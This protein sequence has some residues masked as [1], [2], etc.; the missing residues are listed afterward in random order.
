MSPDQRRTTLWLLRGGMVLIVTAWISAY[1]ALP[2]FLSPVEFDWPCSVYA[3]ANSRATARHTFEDERNYLLRFLNSLH[4]GGATFTADPVE[5]TEFSERLIRS[6][7]RSGYDAA[8]RHLHA[9]Y[10]FSQQF[11]VRSTDYRSLELLE[12]RFV[13]FRALPPSFVTCFE[14]KAIPN[15]RDYSFVFFLILIFVMFGALETRRDDPFSWPRGL[16]P[17]T[18]VCGVTLIGL[19]PALG[20]QYAYDGAGVGA[21]GFFATCCLATAAIAMWLIISAPAWRAETLT[22]WRGVLVASAAVA[23]LTTVANALHLLR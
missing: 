1:I 20:I 2:R 21:L 11:H 13:P 12:R 8:G 7:A 14:P 23:V 15:A 6:L 10:A 16:H 4:A 19:L 22:Q 9:Y 5:R 3:R 18:L 17:V